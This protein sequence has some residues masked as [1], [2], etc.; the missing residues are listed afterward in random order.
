[1]L[2]TRQRRGASPMNDG[3]CTLYLS[4]T[5]LTSYVHYLLESLSAQEVLFIYIIKHSPSY[6]LTI[7][8]FPIHIPCCFIDKFLTLISVHE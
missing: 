4:Y 5:D 6:S 2:D 8:I 1:M 7:G 3:Q